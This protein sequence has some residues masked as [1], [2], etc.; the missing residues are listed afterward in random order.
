MTFG[1]I[2]PSRVVLRY[3]QST[4]VP[5]YQSNNIIP[6]LLI[7]SDCIFIQSVINVSN[8]VLFLIE[9]VILEATAEKG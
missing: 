4:E 1:P 5:E 2:G 8:L 7:I 9:Y 3:E 6:A